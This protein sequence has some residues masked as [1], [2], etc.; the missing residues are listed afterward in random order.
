MS[1]SVKR[2]LCSLIS[3][4][5]IGTASACSESPNSACLEHSFVVPEG[6][7]V[8]IVRFEEIYVEKS[9]VKVYYLDSEKIIREQRFF[10]SGN[11]EGIFPSVPLPTLEENNL[12]LGL[13]Y[14]H[15]SA[16]VVFDDLAEKRQGYANILH[17]TTEICSAHKFGQK[18]R[19]V[20]LTYV[21]IHIPHGKQLSSGSY[22]GKK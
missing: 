12:F 14:Y 10:G 18:D 3:S 20:P 4:L 8:E 15:G 7:S 2:N 22:Q 11:G 21:E 1:F 13:D 19:L 5:L 6:S 16:V 9:F 17:Y